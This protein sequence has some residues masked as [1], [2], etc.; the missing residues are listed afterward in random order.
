[1]GYKKSSLNLNC[2]VCLIMSVIL[3]D[4]LVDDMEY[5]YSMRFHERKNE[6]KGDKMS[7]LPATVGGKSVYVPGFGLS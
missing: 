6:W 1:M 2:I 4:C 5:Y 7:V 3:K